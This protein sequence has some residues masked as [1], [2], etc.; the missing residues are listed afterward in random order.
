MVFRKINIKNCPYYFFKDM[1]NVKTFDPTLLGTDKMPFKKIDAVTYHT[2]YI[3]MKSL[4]HVNV[5]SENSLY[6]VLKNVDG[7]IIEENNENKYL[8]FAFTKKKV[9]KKYTKLWDKIKNQI[10]TI[11]G[12][13]QIEYKKHFMKSRFDDLDDH[14]P[15]AKVLSIAVMVSTRSVFQEGNKYYPQVL[16]HGCV[17]KSVYKL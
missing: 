17:Y 9:L 8:D 12:G 5:D 11:N 16:L 1:V 3:T 13:K 6:L 7:Y 4:D 14:L 10:E 2:T 15:L